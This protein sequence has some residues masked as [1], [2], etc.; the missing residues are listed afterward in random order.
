MFVL[1]I[2]IIYYFYYLFLQP[3]K[4]AT[5]KLVHNMSSGS[6]CQTQVL[7]RSGLSYDSTTPL[8]IIMMMQLC[9]LRASKTDGYP[10]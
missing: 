10:D 9:I 5:E 2:T 4:L 8:P 6:P 1:F 3:L 7:F